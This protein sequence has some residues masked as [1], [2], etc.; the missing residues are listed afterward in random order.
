MGL[1]NEIIGAVVAEEALVKVDP[2]A[3]L[4]KKGLAMIAGAEGEKMIEN[5]I[6]EATAQPTD[7]TQPTDGSQT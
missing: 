4:I 6:D 3:G 2:D 1:L 7:G 5:K